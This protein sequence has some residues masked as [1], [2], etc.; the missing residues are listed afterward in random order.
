MN[1]RDQAQALEL[2]CKKRAGLGSW[3]ECGVVV[4]SYRVQPLLESEVNLGEG[5]R[6]IDSG[7]LEQQ[8]MSK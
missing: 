3:R 7:E 6:G 2:G 1:T 5:R 8:L 4:A